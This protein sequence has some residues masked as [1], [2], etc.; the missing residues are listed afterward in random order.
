VIFQS[1]ID[2][3]RLEKLSSSLSLGLEEEE[4]EVDFFEGEKK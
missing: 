1:F 3:S 4:E 2:W